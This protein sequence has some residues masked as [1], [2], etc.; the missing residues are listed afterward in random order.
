MLKYADCFFFSQVLWQRA[1]TLELLWCD[2]MNHNT[3]ATVYKFIYIVYY[4][5]YLGG[6]WAVLGL[7]SFK[8]IWQHETDNDL[9][10]NIFLRPS[11]GGSTPRVLTEYT[12]EVLAVLLNLSWQFVQLHTCA[13]QHFNGKYYILFHYWQFSFNSCT[14][15]YLENLQHFTTHWNVSVTKVITCC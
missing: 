6:F 9:D 8:L 13:S 12:F 15:K 7:E 11:A 3:D 4:R 10:I 5:S 1:W 14:A 2:V